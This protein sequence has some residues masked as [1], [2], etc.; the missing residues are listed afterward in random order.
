LV[1]DT[2]DGTYA[3][4]IFQNSVLTKIFGM[5]RNEII[6]S[7]RKEQNEGLHNFYSSPDIIRMSKLSSM[8][9]ARHVAHTARI[10]AG[11][12]WESHKE[13]DN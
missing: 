5:K 12:W 3:E 10:H 7:W 8:R 2:K 11:F 6:G 4:G 13:R 9:W 1:S